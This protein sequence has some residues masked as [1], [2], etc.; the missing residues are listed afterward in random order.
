MSDSAEGDGADPF[1]TAAA[2]LEA[3]KF[4]LLAPDRIC[5]FKIVTC[6]KEDVK[7]KPG[8]QML[9]LKLVTEKDYT[10]DEGKPLRAGF[11]STHRL[12]LFEMPE[13]DKFRGKTWKDVAEDTGMLLKACGKGDVAVQ[14]L[15]GRPNEGR[16]SLEGGNPGMLDGQVVDMKVGIT[17]E[18]G[19]FP[20]SNNFKFVLPG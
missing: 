4:P 12:M 17:P 18:K 15:I 8:K 6:V 20:A 9:V 1:A 11:R 19:G 16:T 14:D 3:P 2:N 7:D 10:S 13:T 5:R